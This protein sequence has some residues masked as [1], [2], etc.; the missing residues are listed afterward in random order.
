MTIQVDLKRYIVIAQI[1]ADRIKDALEHIAHLRPI[2]PML[3]EHIHLVDL[4]ILELASNRFAK[5]QDLITTKIF[6]LFLKAIHEDIPSQ[7]N[8]DRLNK[9]EKL[10]IIDDAELW[11]RLR[12]TRNS[13]AHDYPDDLDDTASD[14]NKVLEQ[15]EILIAFFN[16]FKH[17]IARVLEKK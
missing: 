1:H 5:L 13:L 11:Y 4:G 6:P 14:L 10:H 2:T 7:T 8:I 16:E 3:L 17:E 9:L 15:A 12:E